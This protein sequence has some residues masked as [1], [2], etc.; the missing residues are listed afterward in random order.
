[1]KSTVTLV[2]LLFILSASAGAQ[3]IT[4]IWKGY[5]VQKSF[6]YFEDRY[7]F[8]IQLEQLSNNAL[9][10]VTYSYKTTVFYGK[11]EMKGIYTKKTN[12]IVFNETKLVDVKI[13]DQSQPCLMT[14]YLEYDK[15]GSLQTLS[16][17]YT[18][19]NLKDGSDCGSGKVYLEKATESDFYKE[20]FLVKQ[21]KKNSLANKANKAPVAKSAQKEVIKPKGVKPGA[22]ENLV[23][24]APEVSEKKLDL[25][26]APPVPKKEEIVKVA[27]PDRKITAKPEIL[28]KRSN[29]VVQTITTSAREIKIDLYDNGEIDG[30]MISVFHNNEMIVNR[31]I[32]AHKPISFTIQLNE[33]DPH[34]EFV[35]VAENLGSIPPNTALMVV[36][37]GSKRHELFITST[38]QKNAVVVFDYKPED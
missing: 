20:D 2:F 7:R 23:R 12:N 16:G 25:P 31:K 30:D 8:E 24:K 6:G 17:T 19:R 5:F 14:C 37:A 3:N 38:E 33:D 18:S 27:P 34:H 15:M 32:L 36:T 13:G 21:D 22:E 26:V 11:A 10:G 28:K 35:L 29:D 4:G 9:N 1:M